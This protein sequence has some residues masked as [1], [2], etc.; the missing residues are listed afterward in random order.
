MATG[1]HESPASVR[2]VE[3]DA[4]AVSPILEAISSSVPALPIAPSAGQSVFGARGS[5][6]FALTLAAAQGVSTT[7]Q[8][9][10]GEVEAPG[11]SVT[12]SAGVAAGLNVRIQA[13]GNPPAKK[14]PN[15]SAPLAMSALA[16]VNTVVPGFVPA[17][18]SQIASSGAQASFIPT[19]LPQP[20][21]PSTLIVAASVQRANV[22]NETVPSGLQAAVYAAS[23]KSVASDYAT[24]T[25][26]AGVFSSLANPGGTAGALAN[27]TPINGASIPG[28]TTGQANGQSASMA[29]SGQLPVLSPAA[30]G[31][32][33]GG[34]AVSPSIAPASPW[35]RLQSE[36]GT[37]EPALL[38]ANTQ[39]AV[40]SAASGEPAPSAA[41]QEVLIRQWSGAQSEPGTMEPVLLAANT[42]PAVLSTTTGQPGSGTAVP[43]VISASEGSGSQADSF[44]VG[45]A[46]P[47]AQT[48]QTDQ[49]VPVLLA[50][51]NSGADVAATV[52]PSSGVNLQIGPAN[53]SNVPGT[54]AQTNPSAETGTGNP[55]PGI[56]N[57]QASALPALNAAAQLAPGRISQRFVA[58]R[59]TAA[60]TSP[61]VRGAGAGPGASS[62]ILPAAVATGSDASSGSANANQTPFSVFFSSPGPGAESAA[63]TLP[64]MI[65][66]ATSSAIR[67]S[68]AGGTAVSSASPQS[69]G[70]HSGVSQSGT[71]QNPASPNTASPNPGDP[72][73]SQSGSLQAGPAL[74]RDADPSAS[75]PLASMPAGAASGPAAPTSAGTALPLVQ[76]AAPSAESLP[77][78]ETLPGAAPG[79]PAT[80][81]LAT[82]ENP[83][84]TVPGPVQVAQMVSR[85]GQSEMRIGMNTSAFGSV[86]VRTVVHASDVGL[87]IGSEK[88]DLRGLLTNEMPAITS[89]LQ[90]QNLRLNSVNFMQGFAF[91]NNASGGGAS[92]QQR[93][94]VPMNSSASSA[95]ALPEAAAEDSMELPPM[96][97]FGGGGSGLSILA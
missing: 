25:A 53:S 97:A 14:L 58:P 90:Q 16:A 33:S 54:A 55:L 56:L 1:V 4:V 5:G 89:T 12:K 60:V 20:S 69:G 19:N 86:E 41:L 39:S 87:V 13:S 37:A 82:A 68:Q 18:A 67:D 46:E 92:Q 40:L 50:N 21:L 96:A 64:K 88:G 62:S 9:V 72:V 32:V 63:S 76:Q 75:A 49:A 24:P 78:P 79:T 81:V 26:T 47:I 43:E 29:N 85:V 61:T 70:W 83:A 84:V 66:P 74:H 95:S 91:S 77:K 80:T 36:P 10:A 65:L 6:G 22:T 7:A 45:A 93:S 51:A 27:Q 11:E 31:V 15:G 48:A 30:G 35:S 42:Q 44:G 8:S 71:A 34:T 17:A 73:G 38:A 3:P 52:L 57:G 28:Q 59:V 2:I 94:F 23:A